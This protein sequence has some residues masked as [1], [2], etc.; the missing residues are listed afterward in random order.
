MLYT[1]L[2]RPTCAPWP[3]KTVIEWV[4]LI[5]LISSAREKFSMLPLRGIG[6]SSN[7]HVL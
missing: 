2:M 4:S 7:I 3:M 6:H 1:G 5:E